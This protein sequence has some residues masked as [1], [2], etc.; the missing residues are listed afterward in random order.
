M[1]KLFLLA[2]ATV[3]LGTIP[4]PA[5][6]AVIWTF[7][8]TSCTELVPDS[9][10]CPSQPGVTFPFPFPLITVTVPG[11]TSN[12]TAD[13]QGD[14]GP[15][16]VYTG[17]PFRLQYSALILTPAFTGSGFGC[18]GGPPTIC[19]FNISWSATAGQL[20]RVSLLLL[21]TFDNLGGSGGPPFGL[22]G[23]IFGSDGTVD[24]CVFAQ[25]LATG[26]WQSDL[27][28]PMSV[29]LLASALLGLAVARRFRRLGVSAR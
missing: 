20:T 1:Y 14:V 5:H 13:W 22:T 18:G 10:P 29:S 4:P 11:P 26:F 15:P 7:Y 9:G 19:D 16:P 23:G 17:D 28:E 12:F 25:C 27:P 6:A 24:D 21:G 8:E 2:L 3:A